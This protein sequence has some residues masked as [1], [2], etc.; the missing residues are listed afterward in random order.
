MC[1]QYLHHIH[2]PIPFPHNLSPPT[3][4]NPPSRICTTLLLSN[5]LEE[6]RTR[7]ET[8]FLFGWDKSSYTGSL[9]D[10]TPIDLSS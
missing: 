6:K 7:K 3:G 8:T 1:S 9:L 10:I 4:T 5:L 2:H